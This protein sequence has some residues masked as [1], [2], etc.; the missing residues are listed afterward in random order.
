MLI[1]LIQSLLF[2]FISI[3]M[4]AMDESEATNLTQ[5]LTNSAPTQRIK[6][7]PFPSLTNCTYTRKNTVQAK[8]VSSMLT[9]NNN[10]KLENWDFGLTENWYSNLS[11]NPVEKTI[12]PEPDA[13]IVKP[14][15]LCNLYQKRAPYYMMPQDSV[16][17]P[18]TA[19]AY[20]AINE[21]MK[22]LAKTDA[23]AQKLVTQALLY[24]C[25]P[26]VDYNAQ[27]L[28]HNAIQRQDNIPLINNNFLANIEYQETQNALD[29]FHFLY[30][31][32]QT[33]NLAPQEYDITLQANNLITH[34]II[35]DKQ[36]NPQ[37]SYGADMVCPSVAYILQACQCLQ[38]V[39]SPTKET[40]LALFNQ[41]FC[42]QNPVMEVVCQF[43]INYNNPK[44]SPE[45]V[46]KDFLQFISNRNMHD[47]IKQIPHTSLEPYLI[48][49]LCSTQLQ[50]RDQVLLNHVIAQLYFNRQDFHNAHIYYSKN[51]PVYLNQQHLHSQAFVA[52]LNSAKDFS[53]EDVDYLLS[54][55]DCYQRLIISPTKPHKLWSGLSHPK[56]S[57][58]LG[59]CALTLLSSGKLFTYKIKDQ[60]DILLGGI[61][62]LTYAQKHGIW[63]TQTLAKI[64]DAQAQLY[65]QLSTIYHNQ[66]EHNLALSKMM[67]AIAYQS[68]YNNN[69]Q[70]HKVLALLEKELKTNANIY[71]YYTPWLTTM[72]HLIYNETKQEDASLKHNYESF[73][74]FAS[75]GLCQELLPYLEQAFIANKQNANQIAYLLALFHQRN[76]NYLKAYNYKRMLSQNSPYRKNLIKGIF[77]LDETKDAQ[78]ILHALDLLEKDKQNPNNPIIKPLC[79]FALNEQ[80]IKDLIAAII[81]QENIAHPIA[82]IAQTPFHSKCIATLEHAASKAND[83]TLSYEQLQKMNGWLNAINSVLAEL[84]F[85]AGRIKEADTL[86]Q[87]TL[88]YIPSHKRSQEICSHA[89]DAYL[90]NAVSFFKN[91]IKNQNVVNYFASCCGNPKNI[92]P[93][94]PGTSYKIAIL[95]QSLLQN[96]TAMPLEE[97][98]S[99]LLHAID[100]VTYA[101]THGSWKKE[102]QKD[103]I[104]INQDFHSSLATLY[105]STGDKTASLKHIKETLACLVQ[106]NGD[107]QASAIVTALTQAEQNNSELYNKLVPYTKN[108]LHF[109]YDQP[110]QMN[111][112]IDRTLLAQMISSNLCEL[113]P[114]CKQAYTKNKC[115]P[116]D[117]QYIMALY[118]KDDNA[119]QST[120]YAFDLVESTDNPLLTSACQLVLNKL[121]VE[122]FIETI[123]SQKDISHAISEVAQTPLCSTIVSILENSTFH[124]DDSLSSE[125][126]CI[127]AELYYHS[128][129]IGNANDLYKTII[130]PTQEAYA[131]VR[132]NAFNAYITRTPLFGQKSIQYLSSLCNVTARLVTFSTTDPQISLRIGQ[133]THILLTNNNK[134]SIAE[135]ISLLVNSLKHLAYAQKNK[136]WNQ[137]QFNET[138]QLVQEAHTSL[139]VLYESQKDF[140]ATLKH[141][142]HTLEYNVQ[143]GKN[144][145]DGEIIAILTQAEKNN[146]ELYNK[147]APYTKN[148]LNFISDQQISIDI[149]ID[150]ALLPQFISSDLCALL[151]YCKQAYT[152]NKNIS[153]DIKYIMALYNADNNDASIILQALNL[154]EKDNINSD[155]PITKAMC[156]FILNELPA[157]SFVSTVASEKDV[158]QAVASIAQTPFCSKI[159][160]LLEKAAL[161]ANNSLLPDINCILAELYYCRNDRKK[162]HTLYSRITQ[163]TLPG[164]H[165]DTVRSHAFNACIE[166]TIKFTKKE[167]AYFASLSDNIGHSLKAIGLTDP[168]ISFNI[169]LAT[170]QFLQTNLT[171]NNPD[172]ISIILNA[173]DHLEYAGNS[174]IW[175][176]NIKNIIKQMIAEFN[177]LLSGLYH[178]QKNYKA[179]LTHCENALEYRAARNNDIDCKAA[180]SILQQA[181]KDNPELYAKYAQLTHNLLLFIDNKTEKI[182]PQKDR[183]LLSEFAASHLCVQLL[184]Y[185]LAAYAT[186]QQPCNDI[187]YLMAFY[188][189]NNKDYDNAF[190]Y[191]NKLE[192]ITNGTLALK[193]EI[194]AFQHQALPNNELKTVLEQCLNNKKEL[195]KQ[196]KQI[197]LYLIAA[198]TQFFIEEQNYTVALK[199]IEKLTADGNIPREI[200]ALAYN[201]ENN[202]VITKNPDL[203]HWLKGLTSNQFYTKIKPASEYDSKANY[204]ISFLLTQKEPIASYEKL[205]EHATAVIESNNLPENMVQVTQKMCAKAYANWAETVTHDQDTYLTLINKSLQYND[206]P[207]TRYQMAIFILNNSNDDRLIKYALQILADNVTADN[208]AK[209]LS[210]I[211]LAKALCNYHDNS[212]RIPL[213]QQSV[214]FNLDSGWS[215]LHN[216]TINKEFLIYLMDIFAGRS[217]VIDQET[218]NN[219]I[220]PKKELSCINLLMGS[221]DTTIKKSTLLKRKTELLIAGTVDNNTYDQLF[222]CIK[223]ITP[224]NDNIIVLFEQFYQY[225]QTHLP[226]HQETVNILLG[227]MYYKHSIADAKKIDWDLLAKAVEHGSLSAAHIFAELH[228][229]QYKKGK[230]DSVAAKTTEQNFIPLLQNDTNNETCKR[231]QELL[232]KYNAFKKNDTAKKEL[233]RITPQISAAKTIVEKE[234][235]FIQKIQLLLAHK[236]E[237]L[238][239]ERENPALEFT[240]AMDDDIYDQILECLKQIKAN[241]NGTVNFDTLP[242]LYLHIQD[243]IQSNNMTAKAIEWY[244]F[245]A[246]SAIKVANNTPSSSDSVQATQI[247]KELADHLLAIAKT[248]NLDAQIILLPY[249]T[250]IDYHCS[251][252]HHYEILDYSRTA[253]MHPDAAKKPELTNLL[254][255]LRLYAQEGHNLPYY[256][257][258]E[259]HQ[260]NYQELKN[261]IMLFSQA[262]IQT[263]D[264]N[265]DTIKVVSRI[266]EKISDSCQETFVPYNKRCVNAKD[267]KKTPDL[268]DALITYTFAAMCAFSNH[269]IT[270]EAATNG[271]TAAMPLCTALKLPHFRVPLEL[272]LGYVYHKRAH[273]DETVINLP[274]LRK[275]VE[276]GWLKAAQDFT[277]L[278]IAQENDHDKKVRLVSES[279]FLPLMQQHLNTNTIDQYS[280]ELLNKYIAL[281]EKPATNTNTKINTNTPP[282]E[283]AT[284]G[285]A[286]A[287]LKI[288]LDEKPFLLLDKK[289][290]QLKLIKHED[291]DEKNKAY[292]FAAASFDNCAYPQ[293]DE[294]LKLIMKKQEHANTHMLY[295]LRELMQGLTTKTY[296][297]AKKSL[298]KALNYGLVIKSARDKAK[299]FHNSYFLKI[300]FCYIQSLLDEAQYP[301]EV[302]CELL[303]IIKTT[304]QESGINLTDFENLF[305]T[306]TDITLPI[307]P[308]WSIQLLELNPA[309]EQRPMVVNTLEDCVKMVNHT[310]N[311]IMN[312]KNNPTETPPP[313]ITI[314]DAQNKQ[315][316]T[317]I[318]TAV[319]LEQR[320][321]V[322]KQKAFAK[323]II[324]DEQYKE[325]LTAYNNVLSLYTQ[326]KS[327]EADQKL[328]QFVKK[329]PSHPCAGMKLA[330]RRL[331]TAVAKN[332]YDSVIKILP[333]ALNAGLVTTHKKGKITS[334]QFH[335][336]N[337]LNL[338]F[339]YIQAIV[340]LTPEDCPADKNLKDIQLSLLEPIKTVLEKNKINLADFKEL[341]TFITAMPLSDDFMLISPEETVVQSALEQQT[342]ETLLAT[343]YYEQAMLEK[344]NKVINFDLL[345]VSAGMGYLPAAQ[346][347]A[348]LSMEAHKTG[349][350]RFLN[351]IKEH[352]FLPLLQQAAQDKDKCDAYTLELITQYTDIKNKTA[353]SSHNTNAES[354]TSS[355]ST[356][357]LTLINQLAHEKEMINNPNYTETSTEYTQAKNFYAKGRITEGD[358]CLQQ[359]YK[360]NKNHPCICLRFATRHLAQALKSKEYKHTKKLLIEGLDNSLVLKTDSQHIKQFHNT[361]ALDALCWYLDNL[362]KDGH[363]SDI[364]L[365]IITII[366]TKLHDAGIHLT[367]FGTI[368]QTVRGINLLESPQW[369]KALASPEEAHAVLNVSKQEKRSAPVI[370]S[371][372]KEK[373]IAVIQE[374]TKKKNLI[375]YTNYVENSD[376]FKS[377]YDLATN[378]GFR[379]DLSLDNKRQIYAQIGQLLDTVIKKN[380]NHACAHMAIACRAIEKPSMTQQDCQQAK[381]LLEKALNYG[382][383][384]KNT[385]E[386]TKQFHSINYI[387]ILLEYAE[388]LLTGDFNFNDTWGLLQTLRTHLESA[389]IN[390]DHFGQLF[391][392][393]TGIDLLK[394]PQWSTTMAVINLDDIINNAE[395]D[396]N[397]KAYNDLKNSIIKDHTNKELSSLFLDSVNALAN[398]DAQA[399][400]DL[401]LRAA[402]ED[403]HP[404]A[405]LLISRAYITGD[406]VEPNIL[407]A[408]QFLDKALQ[409]GIVE[410]KFSNA[411]TLAGFCNYINILMNSTIP[412]LH[413]Q[414]FL[415]TIKQ[416]LREHS[417]D[418]TTFCTV[419]HTENKIHLV[420][421][422]EWIAEEG[423]E[424]DEVR[425]LKTL[426]K[427]EKL[428]KN[429]YCYFILADYYYQQYDNKDNNNLAEKHLLEALSYALPAGKSTFSSQDHAKG[430][431]TYI[432]LMILRE[433]PSLGARKKFL[434]IIY[435]HFIQNKI[436]FAA[437]YKEFKAE[438]AIDLA[439]VIEWQEIIKEEKEKEYAENDILFKS[440]GQQFSKILKEKATTLQKSNS[441][442]KGI[443]Q[444]QFSSTQPTSTKEAFV[445][446]I[447]NKINNSN[448]DVSPTNRANPSE[449]RKRLVKNIDNSDMLADSLK[450]VDMMQEGNITQ[451]LKLMH[452]IAETQQ[453]PS[454]CLLLTSQYFQGNDVKQDYAM[455][456]KFLSD[457]LAYGIV[458]KQ[459]CNNIFIGTLSACIKVI[460]TNEGHS[461]E[462][463]TSL[464]SIIKTN[465]FD[466][467]ITFNDFYE[468]INEE[469]KIDLPTHKPW[470][471]ASWSTN[472]QTIND[473]NNLLQGIT[474]KSETQKQVITA[475][476]KT[477]IEDLHNITV[478]K[479][480]INVCLLLSKGDIVAA[481][482]LA[483]EIAKK[484]NDPFACIVTANSYLTGQTRK[485]DITQAIAF[486]KKSFE[487]GLRE[488]QFS[489]KLYLQN[490]C[491]LVN[492]IA[493]S[494]LLSPTKQQ[495]FSIIK[496]NLR[497]HK[498]DLYDFKLIVQH[499]TKA[500]L[501]SIAEWGGTPNNN[502][503][504]DDHL[505]IPMLKK[506]AS[507]DTNDTY[508]AMSYFLATKEDKQPNTPITDFTHS[509]ILPSIPVVEQIVKP[510]EQNPTLV[511][512]T[513]IKQNLVNATPYYDNDALYLQGADTF[514]QGNIKKGLEILELSISLNK[515][516]NAQLFVSAVYLLGQKVVKNIEKAKNLLRDSFDNC[517][518][519]NTFC[520]EPFLDLLASY[521][522]IIFAGDHSKEDKYQLCTIIRTALL[523]NKINLSE[524]YEI[525]YKDTDIILSTMP[526]WLNVTMVTPQQL[527]SAQAQIATDSKK[528]LSSLS[529]TFDI[530]ITNKTVTNSNKSAKSEIVTIKENMIHDPEVAPTPIYHA[531]VQEYD[532]K[533]LKTGFKLLQQCIKEEKNPGA[534]LC[535]ATGHLTGGEIQKN[536][537]SS[538]EHLRKA[539]NYAF[540]NQKFCNNDFLLGLLNYV[541][542]IITSVQSKQKRV[543]LLSIIK[544]ALEKNK[545]NLDDFCKLCEDHTQH[546]FSFQPKKI[547]IMLPLKPVAHK[548]ENNAQLVQKPTET[549]DTKIVSRVKK[550]E[551]AVITIDPTTNETTQATNLKKGLIKNPPSSFSPDIEKAKILF[552][553]KMAA[554]GISLLINAAKNQ[555]D[556]CACMILATNFLMGN[557]TDENISSSKAYLTDA[558]E[559]G[560]IKNQFCN[561]NFPLELGTYVKIILTSNLSSQDKELTLSIIKN[562]LIEHQISLSRFC[563]IVESQTNQKLSESPEW[564]GTKKETAPQKPTETSNQQIISGLKKVKA[565]LS[566]MDEAAININ[567]LFTTLNQVMKPNATKSE[568]PTE[569][570]KKEIIAALE[571]SLLKDPEDPITA[572]E[573][574]TIE[575][576]KKNDDK[577]TLALLRKDAENA[578]PWACIKLASY[579]LT[580]KVVKQDYS[581]VKDYL[582]DGLSFSLKGRKFSNAAFLR[583][584]YT[585]MHALLTEE[586][587]QEIRDNILAMIHTILKR[588]EIN[589]TNFCKL[590]DECYQTSLPFSLEQAAEK[591]ATLTNTNNVNNHYLE[592]SII[593]D[594]EDAP[595]HEF[596]VMQQAIEQGNYYKATPIA[597]QGLLKQDP[598]ISIY[599]ATKA[600]IAKD[601]DVSEQSLCYALAH[602]IKEQKLCSALFGSLLCEYIHQMIQKCPS[603]QKIHNFLTIIRKELERNKIDLAIFCQLFQTYAGYPLSFS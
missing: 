407:T 120:I 57:Y 32:A 4:Y 143:H 89:C 373:R 24:K 527:S 599:G 10:N 503:N 579:H 87:A 284:S 403:N 595:S 19:Q 460:L 103:M 253:L 520:N 242:A 282:N 55:K 321:I 56:L 341:F 459:F 98:K 279:D 247:Q 449:L 489:N 399:Y 184:P 342:Q 391:Q 60:K 94:N 308:Q 164:A 476:E 170:D 189:K 153:R 441:K 389:G 447:E 250:A 22:E 382:L 245:A 218:K 396:T 64:A 444:K 113:L 415:N 251:G 67:Q 298:V 8:K 367:N 371:V 466:H 347:L 212:D 233:D 135:K 506:L 545:I 128:N 255:T 438:H 205:I 395:N 93:T 188:C 171:I 1:G 104:L 355:C 269:P 252:I 336:I 262:K 383:I 273:L 124:Q 525:V 591:K 600:L 133:L 145:R 378:L 350:S 515:N 141:T 443:L 175:N 486:L 158:S 566:T 222:E 206:T 281:K 78:I 27:L 436:D 562:K 162:A 544:Q 454:I 400:F 549:S 563:A 345:L 435:K 364:M 167:I 156:Q 366:K 469:D 82:E 139:S 179:A 76:G 582:R 344:Q 92:E 97:R 463:R 6:I 306:L 248:N 219:Y 62:H 240:Q 249:C 186:H 322:L 318:Q 479:E 547:G 197:I 455:A 140:P 288:L 433:E 260:K 507:D 416:A 208:E 163:D 137:K 390:E 332:N 72:L 505:V 351:L 561:D 429:S 198:S 289:A 502:N 14:R 144:E 303:A 533:N 178:T 328:E 168:K 432:S 501:F 227:H 95:L 508:E 312:I 392:T 420:T 402:N 516:P 334:S 578:R 311:K 38:A 324:K 53:A 180:L 199:L 66:N 90:T 587:S 239:A 220:D 155:N 287:K 580:G 538:E 421:K 160:T 426:E 290:C 494:L 540:I 557:V 457:G 337:F 83:P 121:S 535:F 244:C 18:E 404:G 468:I 581:K 183:S 414:H 480:S 29:L 401:T 307:T 59:Q 418:R 301:Y 531:A 48:T 574:A 52:C 428:H 359:A 215:L 326:R 42:P 320:E 440:L 424:T 594:P 397:T 446:K 471:D 152:T 514:N 213:L 81:A 309:Q 23:T 315:I 393:I 65:K 16:L 577:T 456:E 157:A 70:D 602:G 409:H 356:T 21:S 49:K 360:K 333:Q 15:D 68:A 498:I 274:L 369:L 267:R 7:K 352:N 261:I 258:C 379:K 464:L 487:L 529:T 510:K 539:L 151:P 596:T 485:R 112:P 25:I 542:T 437:F 136:R 483:E 410:N 109:I 74:H 39:T 210:L 442:N 408:K 119:A 161:N 224:N 195:N 75:Y 462:I 376:E 398:R 590:Y 519:E 555:H 585:L 51:S 146:S 129:Q 80:P 268:I 475:L 453:C 509:K 117:I 127:L 559:Y 246:E 556:A 193:A 200:L 484:T 296:E 597:Q 517:C 593:K 363:S 488:N 490:L 603:K 478:P 148:I 91:N 283:T 451:S 450:A 302:Q 558:L 61:D 331:V 370:L 465:L 314:T 573:L 348:S 182:E 452:H 500:N 111:N 427:A 190:T 277:E 118:Y 323:K 275:A 216:Q 497:D 3:P 405:C 349:N 304:L 470:R 518:I 474:K 325:S 412:S 35:Y 560:L 316:E 295:A 211:P 276:F 202:F 530:P 552:A 50:P 570:E 209:T 571:K 37:D 293:V 394:S 73:T 461:D 425:D 46:T 361:D 241:S 173:L 310:N 159:I 166:S 100:H 495:L 223:Q 492:T 467:K 481:V 522:G 265:D 263:L 150:L 386:K 272:L 278:Y 477:I 458:G 511:N 270:L 58:G 125:L 537:N 317:T 313:L 217:A 550:V 534:H 368:F 105:D 423:A 194:Y 221:D 285:K 406:Q 413:K 380:P 589:I 564:I 300:L 504:N 165:Y 327:Q 77:S 192:N 374:F 13:L 431:W 238:I 292:L 548:Q 491:N 131:Q 445:K 387:A 5:S 543:L 339:F 243:L 116:R 229:E 572:T 147:L 107:A 473:C 256:M 576:Y 330:L 338:L 354:T 43:L 142:K 36:G 88:G 169:A 584:L 430:I 69:E 236:N 592:V 524:F 266:V 201:V 254:Q 280:L 377:A 340:A 31:L 305:K 257:L 512:I 528:L 96:N 207:I 203:A 493:K 45:I 40:A 126:N 271:L 237:L 12:Q 541:K 71:Q 234:K 286:P 108:I 28:L 586:H 568:Q 297:S 214:T 134:I 385:R 353:P 362:L 115:I 149:P 358:N 41:Q 532:K 191:I 102:Y 79:L 526:A 123:R 172:K 419:V 411:K 34:K 230:N 434:S 346:E 357:Q 110:L 177:H 567:T 499:E 85:H 9:N 259:H 554:E 106:Y 17:K 33:N 20:K 472:P 384:I 264:L 187:L 196:E 299:Q 551:T 294:A 204:A 598:L 372:P 232:E 185:C 291:Y 335:N 30:P 439:A 235:L 86:Y 536:L 417:I 513:T 388:S 226:D 154:L 496:T 601:Y 565:D 375:K 44:L 553:Q 575:A 448:K 422:S 583:S 521:I 63:N 2:I 47:I 228:I 132:S 176:E 99:L 381:I 114:Y 319:P 174:D 138:Q 523:D 225:I 130:I 482:T 546:S 365:E 122:S 84:Y 11:S 54:L 343:K 101:Q 181:K 569:E 588:Y 26:L 231:S 329:N